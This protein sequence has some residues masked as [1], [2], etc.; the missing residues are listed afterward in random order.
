MNL[1]HSPDTT[2]AVGIAA[3][4]L[5]LTF[6]A[7]AGTVSNARADYSFSGDCVGSGLLATSGDS[8]HP[9][10]GPNCVASVSVGSSPSP[11]LELSATGSIFE[12]TAHAGFLYYFRIDTSNP[13]DLIPITLNGSYQFHGD[14]PA[15][16]FLNPGVFAGFRAV[17][18]G[19]DN[20]GNFQSIGVA[21]SGVEYS[22]FLSVDVDARPGHPPTYA[23]L[24]PYL[25]IDSSWLIS[26]PGASIVLSEGIGNAAA[27]TVPETGSLGLVALGLGLLGFAPLRKRVGAGE[28]K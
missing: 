28:L 16:V 12:T 8:V 15:N 4:A 22:I 11:F 17:N 5:L 7:V 6:N 14:G 19:A 18:T 21:T 24:D 13:G 1:P 9:T 25:R 27:G 23:L 26:H 3:L 10:N 2:K 20:G